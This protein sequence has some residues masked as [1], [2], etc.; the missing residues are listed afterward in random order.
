MSNRQQVQIN[1]MIEALEMIAGMP[2]VDPALNL[3]V[4]QVA[5]QYEEA[6]E[7]ARLAVAQF[8]RS[9]EET[10]QAFEVKGA[11]EAA[12]GMAH[13]DSVVAL[14][15]MGVRRMVALT[16]EEYL[17]LMSETGRVRELACYILGRTEDL[18][19]IDDCRD[20]VEAVRAQCDEEVARG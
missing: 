17:K 8:N 4:G 14:P 19:T 6:R 16:E 7:T 15:G 12:H 3:T 13:G 10:G 20:A 1:M 9:E 2:S 11:V 5:A 18:K